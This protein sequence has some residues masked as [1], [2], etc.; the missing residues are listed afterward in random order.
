MEKKVKLDKKNW[1]MLG[2]GV[3]IGIVVTVIYWTLA[4]PKTPF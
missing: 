1:M 3:V 2:L 4:T